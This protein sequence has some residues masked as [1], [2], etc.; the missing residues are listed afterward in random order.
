MGMEN[1]NSHETL[2]PRPLRRI[3]EGALE[4]SGNCSP[5]T[6]GISGIEGKASSELGEAGLG[7]P[8]GSQSVSQSGY[9]KLLEEAAVVSIGHRYIVILALLLVQ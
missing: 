1:Y 3:E 4:S 8:G 9:L 5:S 7:S 2:R 6:S